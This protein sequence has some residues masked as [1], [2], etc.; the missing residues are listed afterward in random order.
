MKKKNVVVIGGGNGSAISLVALKQN[1]DLFDISAV[2]AMSDSGGSSGKLRKEFGTLPPGDVLRAILAL[3]R[4]DY[5]LLKKIFNGNRFSA[6][7]KLSGHNLGNIFLTLTEQ[8]AGDF[9]M[10]IRAL[11]ESVEAMGRVYPVT[12]ANCDL[13]AELNN[14]KIIRTE[15]AIDKPNYSRDLRIKKVWLDPQVKANKEAISAI[16]SADYIVLSPGSLYTS[17]VATLLPNG[18]KE[19]IKKSNAKMV[20]VVGNAYHTDGET[21]PEYLS[22]TVKELEMYLPRPA[23]WILYNIH[24][25]TNKELAFYKTRNWG[26]IKYDPKNLPKRSIVAFD[27]SRTGGGLCSI[28]LGKKLKEILKS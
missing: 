22:E 5:L 27:F 14:K 9:N 20:F 26:T 28:K 23:D 12:L 7:N 6:N 11:E 24:K 1:V 25:L 16:L 8:Y 21:G 18:I 2:I 3:S 17:V 15:A 10:A 19:A 13:V 4:Y